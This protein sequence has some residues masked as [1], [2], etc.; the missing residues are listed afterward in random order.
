LISFNVFVKSPF[1]TG[2]LDIDLEEMVEQ[3]NED[4]VTM[5]TLSFVK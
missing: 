1:E 5:K 2:I 4:G 3:Q